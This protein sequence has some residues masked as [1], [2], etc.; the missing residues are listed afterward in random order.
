MAVFD[1]SDETKF[2][3]NNDD[4]AATYDGFCGFRRGLAAVGGWYDTVLNLQRYYLDRDF[5]V[6]FPGTDELDLLAALLPEEGYAFVAEANPNGQAVDVSGNNVTVE[7]QV[8]VKTLDEKGKKTTY[9][10]WENS[11]NAANVKVTF[12]RATGILTGTCDL[13]YEG[14]DPNV[15]NAKFTQKAYTGCKH[16]G[17]LLW[18]RD[19]GAPLAD[20]IW[21]AG[22]VVIPQTISYLDEKNAKKS[23]K[24]NASLRFNVKAT[25]V[26]RDWSE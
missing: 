17:V 18:N 8:L 4:P 14:T 10:D 23:R 22:A 9:N 25:K 11:V 24:W 1:G 16:A 15:K 5:S 19:D 26:D 13:W 20:D 21:T 2:T 12:K 3:W 6:D 7:K